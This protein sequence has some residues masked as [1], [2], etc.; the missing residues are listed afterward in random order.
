MSVFQTVLLL[1]VGCVLAGSLVAMLKGWA[2]RR[3]GVV[4]SL[5][6]T[7][8]TVAVIWPAVTTKLARTMG[9]GRGT[10]LVLYCS[11]VV[12]IVG[13]VMTYARIRHLR[14]Q[15]TLLVR[16]IALR[17]AAGGKATEELPT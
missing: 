3:E 7:I 14:R 13:F 8:A 12:M 17:D 1:I 10:D 2:T 11:V 15:I 6:A 9:I 16:A 5:I 4:M